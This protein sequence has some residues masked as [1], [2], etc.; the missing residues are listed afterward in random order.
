MAMKFFLSALV[1]GFLGLV[2]QA[3]PIDLPG[4]QGGRQP[5]LTCDT[6]GMLHIVYGLGETIQYLHSSDDGKTFSKP[7]TVGKL[8]KLMVGMRRG[9]RLAVSG[10]TILVT[11][12]SKDL[13]GFTSADGGASWSTAQRINDTENAAR[14]GLHNITAVPD[15]GFYAVWLD[16]RNGRKEIWGAASADGVKWPQRASWP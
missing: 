7:V 5:Q 8:E 4:T 10:K 13:W 2:T 15:K 3:A 9:P 16:D 11:G 1:C 6:Q 14:E 12:N